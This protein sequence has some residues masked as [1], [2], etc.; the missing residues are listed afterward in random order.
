MPVVSS[1]FSHCPE[2][3]CFCTKGHFSHCSFAFAYKPAAFAVGVVVPVKD[4]L[5]E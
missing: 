3:L 5:A 2:F 4:S 1:E